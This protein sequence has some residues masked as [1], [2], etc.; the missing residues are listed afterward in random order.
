M[1]PEGIDMI[2]GSCLC[3]GIRIEAQRVSLL[4]HCHCSSCRK[5]TGS[6]FG[7]VAVVRPSDFRFVSGEDLVQHYRYPPDGTRAFC[8]VCGSKAPLA[9][10]GG[11]LVIVPAGMLDDDPGVRPALH[12]FAGSKAPWWEIAD[13]L[14][15]FERWV[16]GYEPKWAAT[17][18]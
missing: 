18:G 2:R 9:L 11:T 17:Q 1:A 14:P 6:A 15:R 8:R 7:T 5:E 4:R 3:G 10:F 13:S 12:Q 16:P